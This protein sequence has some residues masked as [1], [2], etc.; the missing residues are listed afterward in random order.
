[1]VEVVGFYSSHL[2][3]NGAVVTAER[4][5]DTEISIRVQDDRENM[6][7]DFLM[8]EHEAI[9]LIHAITSVLSK[10]DDEFESNATLRKKDA[11]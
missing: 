7:A 4:Y 10:K 3:Q 6:L 2:W 11:L 8:G 5:S 9:C 1:M